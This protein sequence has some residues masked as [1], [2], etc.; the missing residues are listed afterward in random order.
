MPTGDGSS[1]GG[2]H[3]GPVTQLSTGGTTSDDN[4]TNWI[5]W[6]DLII[7]ENS[8]YHLDFLDLFEWNF[9]TEKRRLAYKIDKASI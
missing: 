9:K 5:I 1:R 4:F 2:Q 7:I 6:A 8:Y 3:V